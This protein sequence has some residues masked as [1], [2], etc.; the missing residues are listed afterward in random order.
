M[1]APMKTPPKAIET[2]ETKQK[3]YV[4]E[5]GLQSEDMQ[6]TPETLAKLKRQMGYDTTDKAEARAAQMAP[7]TKRTMGAAFAKGGKVGS[8]SKRADGIASKGKTKGR[9]C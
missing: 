1:P 2:G 8:A 7:T 5:E 9:V 3:R 6:P 4:R